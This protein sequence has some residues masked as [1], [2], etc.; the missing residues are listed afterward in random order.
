MT[1]PRRWF[2]L[3]LTSLVAFAAGWLVRGW[4]AAPTNQ[5]AVKPTAVVSPNPGGDD[6]LA[7]SGPVD[8]TMAEVLEMAADA[9]QHTIANV[10]DYTATMRQH[11][12]DRSGVL[13]PPASMQIKVR[14]R[15]R[16]GTDGQPMAVYLKFDS[17]EAIAGRE[18]IWIE[19]QND[20]NLLVREA[21]FM[22]A[23]MTAKIDPSGFLAMRGQRYPINQIGLTNLI[24]K[25]IQRGTND[26]DNPNVKAT[27]DA[28]HVIDGQ[29][30]TLIR[31]AK[32]QPSGSPDD[33]SLAEIVIDRERQLIIEFRSFGWPE[34][35]ADASDPPLIESYA[36]ENLRINV[37]LQDIDFDVTNPEYT[38]AE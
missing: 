8:V 35:G 34:A 10:D 25:L 16:G 11:E 2:P 20:G 27:L 18:V 19:D 3:I 15:H 13:Q 23:M 29:S 7:T 9:L 4:T 30:R 17:P 22:G 38:F 21:G 1:T 32:S 6:T 5:T 14:T 36:Y 28:N 37:G 24:S 12:R 26:V 31:I 33:F